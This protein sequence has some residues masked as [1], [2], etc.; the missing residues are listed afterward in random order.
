MKLKM[1]ISQ[2]E[3]EDVSQFSVYKVADWRCCWYLQLRKSA[4]KIKLL[5]GSFD[6]AVEEDWIFAF[7]TPFLLSEQLNMK[8]PITHE[9][10][11]IHFKT[12]S[13]FKT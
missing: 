5:Q 11:I 13:T 3:N 1:F 9:G 12:N 4:E 7:V 10:E 8:I 2:L 6:I